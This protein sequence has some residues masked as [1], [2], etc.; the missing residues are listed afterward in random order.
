MSFL[1][2]SELFSDRIELAGYG[3]LFGAALFLPV[4]FALIFFYAPVRN[5]TPAT[6]IGW[7]ALMAAVAGLGFAL[8]RLR[9]W[10]RLALLTFYLGFG[11]WALVAVRDRSAWYW[12]P[13]VWSVFVFWVLTHPAAVARFRPLRAR[14][15]RTA[16]GLQPFSFGVVVLYFFSAFSLAA[17]IDAFAVSWDQTVTDAEALTWSLHI[18]GA[19]GLAGLAWCVRRLWTWAR[20]LAVL[21]LLALAGSLL[22][23]TFTTKSYSQ[24]WLAMAKLSFFAGFA[25]YLAFSARV[26]RAFARPESAGA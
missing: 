11:L 12:A 4:Y 19:L 6:Q 16:E 18:L 9:A 7:L 13:A 24:Y 17:G 2:E 22:P 26:H 3:T 20:W 21:V 5:Q 8:V 15:L 1:T 23:D 25:G 10:A 14:E